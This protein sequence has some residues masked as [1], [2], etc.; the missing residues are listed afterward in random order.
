MDEF[1]N[2]ITDAFESILSEARK[3]KLGLTIAHQYIG[4]LVDPKTKDEKI[5]NAVFGNVGSMLNF[6]I[7]AQDAE[8]MVKEMAPVFSDQDLINLRGFQTCIKLSIDNVITQPFSMNTYK[9]WE[10]P[11]Q[12]DYEAAEAFKQLSRL[13]YGRDKEFVSR[14]ILRRMAN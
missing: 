10:L 3:Y 11:E 9:T 4:Q 13:K 7:G 8:Y 14:E 5:K 6:K 12:K 1:Q 2:F